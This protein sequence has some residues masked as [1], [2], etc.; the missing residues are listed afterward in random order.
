MKKIKKLINKFFDYPVDLLSGFLGLYVALFYSSHNPDRLTISILIT[1]IILIV[2]FSILITRI[3][4]WVFHSRIFLSFSIRK[5]YLYISSFVFILFAY[6]MRFP[7]Y[8]IVALL[9]KNFRESSSLFELSFSFLHSII[10]LAGMVLCWFSIFYFLVSKKKEIL[11]I[12]LLIL[13]LP[14][15]KT[16]NS[17]VVNLTYT[18]KI[19]SLDN[20]IDKKWIFKKKQNMYFLLFDSYTSPKGLEI[21]G[22]KYSNPEKVKITSFLDQLSKRGFHVYDSFYTNVQATRN[23]LFSYFGLYLQYGDRHIYEHSWEDRN[24]MISERGLVYQIF[25]K[26]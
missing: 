21:L 20:Q 11:L 15:Y 19:Q 10:F 1:N 8:G 23:A 9:L 2:I 17:L 14:L 13:T 26:K 24:K 6:Y 5:R 3:I 4:L 18:S 22:Q 16:I 25:K 7:I 12:Y